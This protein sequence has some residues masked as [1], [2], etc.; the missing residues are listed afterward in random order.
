MYVV[1]IS[2]P[3]CHISERLST[4]AL[5]ISSWQLVFK[6]HLKI[7]IIIGATRLPNGDLRH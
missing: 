4:Q 3:P 7:I 5:M 2:I 6:D 1:S